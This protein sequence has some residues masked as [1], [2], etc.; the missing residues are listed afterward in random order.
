MMIDQQMGISMAQVLDPLFE[1][2]T[3][4]MSQ[5]YFWLAMIIFLSIKGHILLVGAM[6]K[7][8]QTIPPGQFVVN[9][10]VVVSLTKILQVSFVIALQISAPLVAAIFLTTLAMGFVARTVPQ[11]N[12]LSV[13]FSI[14]LVLGYVLILV[15][16]IPA[17]E[18]FR[19]AIDTV[20]LNLYQL[21]GF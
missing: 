6:V 18:I 10:E 14:R 7:S 13:G 11:L 21:L 19:Q 15:C 16:L 12:I 17:M 4:V 2:E 9:E 3:S 5:F 8:L 20:Y 1:E